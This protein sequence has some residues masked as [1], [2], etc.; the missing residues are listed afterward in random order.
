M[1][2][3]IGKKT[4]SNEGLSPTARDIVESLEEYRSYKLGE[5][6]DVEVIRVS[7]NIPENVDVNPFE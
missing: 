1:A 7:P 3:R 5:K 6:T 4:I 2:R